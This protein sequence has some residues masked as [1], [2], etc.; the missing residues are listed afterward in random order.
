[1]IEPLEDGDA[2]GQQRQV[3]RTR[4]AERCDGQVVRPDEPDAALRERPRRLAV[5]PDERLREAG[6]VP[7]LGVRGLEEQPRLVRRNVEAAQFRWP[8]V[9]AERGRIDH[10]CG[11]DTDIEGDRLGPGR[12]PAARGLREVGMASSQQ[13]LERN[14]IGLTEVLFQS[15]THMAPAVATALSLGAATLFAGGNTPLAVVL[16]LIAALFTAYSIG[17]LA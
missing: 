1:Q 15:I 17:E 12:P 8:D 2:G 5:Q 16:A 9:S 7:Q 4:I 14:A 11:P 10:P 3:G 6:L 13:S